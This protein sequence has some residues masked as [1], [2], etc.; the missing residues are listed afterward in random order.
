MTIN[1]KHIKE[2]KIN[3]PMVM[4]PLRQYDELM[5]Y[6]ED[7]EDR[8]AVKE[9]ANDKNIPWSE[10]KKDIRKKLTAKPSKK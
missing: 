7:M 4:F 6:L 2:S 1:V 5:E 3:E 10:V 9:R 8:L